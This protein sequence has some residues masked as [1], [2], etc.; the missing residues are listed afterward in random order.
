MLVVVKLRL[1][2][3]VVEI[4]LPFVGLISGVG[5]LVLKVRVRTVTGPLFQSAPEIVC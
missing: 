2:V 4:R 3:V 1:S 5:E